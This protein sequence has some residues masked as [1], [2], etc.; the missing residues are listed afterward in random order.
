MTKL[1]TIKLDQVRILDVELLKEASPSRGLTRP[2]CKRFL[3]D[4]II[5]STNLLRG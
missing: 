2:P 1:G 4:I 3:T 5:V